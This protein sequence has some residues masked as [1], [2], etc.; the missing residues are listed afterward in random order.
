M[1]Q[2]HADRGIRIAIKALAHKHCTATF[3][4]TRIACFNASRETETPQSMA[5]RKGLSGYA[6][7]SA[8]HLRDAG[9]H[10]RRPR[11]ALQCRDLAGSRLTDAKAKP[12]VMCD[13]GTDASRQDMRLCLLPI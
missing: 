9:G 1:V 8:V 13:G 7:K 3:K 5:H 12:C 10:K 11:N 4:Q 2:R 6:F